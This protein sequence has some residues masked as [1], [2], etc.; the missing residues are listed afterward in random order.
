MLIFTIMKTTLAVLFVSAAAAGCASHHVAK[1]APIGP[2][3]VSAAPKLHIDSDLVASPAMNRIEPLDVVAFANDRSDL[4]SSGLDQ[5]GRAARWLFVHPDRFVVLEGHT[6]ELGAVSYNDSLAGRRIETIRQQLRAWGV[7]GE[8]IVTISYGEREAADPDN[9]NDRRVVMFTTRMA[10]QQVV[11]MQMSQH[12]M[13]VANWVD[14]GQLLEQRA[15]EKP[16][17]VV[18]RR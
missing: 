17:A 13:A 18:G 2:D 12:Q 6:D 4:T 15:G 7:R 9:P 1:N 10:P 5:V 14:R 3:F 11:A 16:T 8:R